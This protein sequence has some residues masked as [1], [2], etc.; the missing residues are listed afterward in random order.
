MGSGTINVASGFGFK[1]AEVGGGK[2]VAVV[3]SGMVLPG[4]I[5]RVRPRTRRVGNG[6]FRVRRQ[7]IVQ[8]RRRPRRRVYVGAASTARS[9]RFQRLIAGKEMVNV[10]VPEKKR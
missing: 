5:R 4:H 3:T 10:L 7:F 2:K 9:S 8:R 1:V 6:R